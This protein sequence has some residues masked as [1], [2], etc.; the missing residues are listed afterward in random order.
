MGGWNMGEHCLCR[1][2]LADSSGVV[3]ALARLNRSVEHRMTVEV[4]RCLHV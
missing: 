1:E 2:V 3:G 4:L